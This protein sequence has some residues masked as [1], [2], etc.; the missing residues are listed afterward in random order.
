MKGTLVR[1]SQSFGAVAVV[2]GRAPLGMNPGGLASHLVRGETVADVSWYTVL[3]EAHRPTRVRLL[4]VGESAPDLGATERRFFY[5]PILDRHDNLFRGVVEA[6]FDAAAG[7]A[8]DAKAP[9]LDRLKAGGAYLIDLV[10]F[11]V[12]KLPARDRARARR[13]HVDACVAE[14]GS[15]RPSGII[16]CHS[17]TFDVL[18]KPLR[19]AG[20]PLLHDER[21][22]FPLGNHRASFVTK[23]RAALAGSG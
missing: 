16:V 18:A 19:T 20:L 12:N 13:D 23:V 8:G 4:F 17:A 21:I 11:P 10:P 15:L 1:C 3:R 6:M 22:P 5:G 14:A 2:A 7:R 9:W